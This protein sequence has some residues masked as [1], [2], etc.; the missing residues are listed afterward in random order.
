MSYTF[1]S[2]TDEELESPNLIEPGI[3]H[4]EVAKAERQTSKAGNPM[5]K[6]TLRVWDNAGKTQ[7]LF[8]Y[9]IF[10]NIALNIRK[11]KHF[12][13]SVGLVEEYQKRELPEELA[14]YCGQVE[15]GI[16]DPQPKA[17]GGMYARKNKV[18]D[19]IVGEVKTPKQPNLP[20]DEFNDDIPF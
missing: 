18:V 10:S 5:A 19:Y 2:F 6:L 16:E 9:L 7:T 13:H 4:F 15:V 12:C 1:P 20:A 8:D 3:Y 11:V 17:G 14:N